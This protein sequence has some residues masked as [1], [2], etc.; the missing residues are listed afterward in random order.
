MS[1]LQFFDAEWYRLQALLEQTLE[2]R[3]QEAWMRAAKREEA[4]RKLLPQG[5]AI[6]ATSTSATTIIGAPS[7]SPSSRA[8]ALPF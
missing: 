5:L 1:L 4:A 6:G 2:R 7:S 3:N 8:V